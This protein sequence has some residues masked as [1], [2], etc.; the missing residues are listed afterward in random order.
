MMF[1][2]VVLAT[3]RQLEAARAAGG[4]TPLA[5][6]DG[7]VL[8]AEEQLGVHATVARL[9]DAETAPL[10]ELRMQLGL[11]YLADGDAASAGQ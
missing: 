2:D 9:Q 5:R 11:A 8:F 1:S 6:G 7:H 10:G 4:R 3:C